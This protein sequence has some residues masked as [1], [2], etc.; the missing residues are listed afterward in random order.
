MHL[1][2]WSLL[3]EE[4]ALGSFA[5][6]PC[7]DLLNTRIALPAESIDL[8]LTMLGKAKNIRLSTFQKFAKS[9]G[10]PPMHIEKIFGQ[11]SVWEKVISTLVP[12]SLLSE[13]AKKEYLKIVRSRVKFLAS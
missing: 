7:Y 10:I 1:K 12:L 9:V 6:S 8:G 11:I 13:A 4:Q 3:E 5:L 2:N